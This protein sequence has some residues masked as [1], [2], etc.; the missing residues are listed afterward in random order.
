M[1]CSKIGFYFG[2][3]YFVTLP[4]STSIVTLLIF[5]GLRIQSILTDVIDNDPITGLSLKN[6]ID[7]FSSFNASV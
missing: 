2:Y 5:T 3:Y 7:S 6:S 1:I 4:F